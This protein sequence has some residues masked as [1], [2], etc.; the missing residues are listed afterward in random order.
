[1]VAMTLDRVRALIRDVPDFPQP[2]ILFKDITPVMGDAA[3]FQTVLD[4]LEERLRGRDFDRV[5]AI[6]SRGFVF[7][8]AL[9]DRL[10]IGFSPVRKLGK[11]PYKTHRI[12]YA[13]EYG[14][15]VL[16]SHVDAVH[17]GE[18]VAVVDDLLATGGT[19]WG[20][21]QL[22]EK[23]QAK[24]GAFLFVVELAFL[25]GRSRL[26]GLGGPVEALIAY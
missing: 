10:E 23:Q 6:E 22:V 9:A 13:L 18:K 25:K 12:E 1:M 26:E 16:E 11:L 4:A 5:V 21:A 15:G 14:K 2:G 20:A 19:A 8:A 24:V 3:A 17:P 7:G